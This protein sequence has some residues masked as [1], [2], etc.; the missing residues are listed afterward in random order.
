MDAEEG[1]E[2]NRKFARAAQDPLLCFR[3]GA[4][5]TLPLPLNCYLCTNCTSLFFI[6]LLIGHLEQFTFSHIFPLLVLSVLSNCEVI[7]LHLL[8]SSL[9]FVLANCSTSNLFHTLFDSL[10]G[11][12]WRILLIQ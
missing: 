7:M 8:Q 3:Y 4:P 12:T 2:S 9:F 11:V 5:L 10:E 1:F 6:N